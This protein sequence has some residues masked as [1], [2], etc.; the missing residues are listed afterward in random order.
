VRRVAEHV[1]SIGGKTG[2]DRFD[3]LGADRPGMRVR[4]PGA[5]DLDVMAEEA[6]V[7]SEIFGHGFADVVL[8]E[9]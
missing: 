7:A 2:D 3:V 5:A 6:L 4:L 1:G 9:E 8:G